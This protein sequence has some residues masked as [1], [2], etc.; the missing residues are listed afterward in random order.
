MWNYN[1][2]TRFL[3]FFSLIWTQ[4]FLWKGLE[5]KLLDGRKVNV[6]KSAIFSEREG[7]RTDTSYTDVVWWPAYT[8]CAVTSS[9]KHGVKWKAAGGCSRHQLQRGEGLWRPNWGRIARLLLLFL[10]VSSYQYLTLMPCC[11]HLQWQKHRA[12]WAFTS[13][14]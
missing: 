9:H 13:I 14:N 6:R 10:H 8:T 4:F 3:V 2:N 12:D 11:R 1:V 7:P 5:K